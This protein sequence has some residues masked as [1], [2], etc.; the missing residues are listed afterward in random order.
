M[1]HTL[2]QAVVAALQAHGVR[3][4]FG[5]PGGGSSLDIIDAAHAVG[6]EFVL[7][8]TESAAAIMAAVTGELSS[9]PGTV[10]TAI[11]PGAASAVNGVAYAWLERAPLVLISDSVATHDV[12]T[13]HQRFDQRALF[14]PVTKRSEALTRDAAGGLDE[15]VGLSLTAPPGPVHL[16]L[17]AAEAG[18]AVASLTRGSPPPPPPAA[19]VSGDSRRA[20]RLLAGAH[21]PVVIA[22]L[23]ARE[24]AACRALRTLLTRMLC[25]V[26]P[27]YKA[28]G[29]VPDADTRV[30][31]MFTG[32][33]AEARCLE[34]ADLIVLY[35][36]DPVELIPGEWRYTAPVLELTAWPQV[37]AP[38][39]PACTLAGPLDELVEVFG[40]D[41]LACQW[42]AGEIAGLRESL[43]RRLEVA[44]STRSVDDVVAALAS[45]APA[46]S[47]LTVDAGAHMF[48][49]MASWQALAPFDVLKSN[50]LSTMAYA[51][52]AGIA[53]SLHEPQ[54]WVIAVTGDGGLMM[55]L[56][57]LA[58]AA[59]LGCRIVVV[60]CNDAA[61]SLIDVKQ[62]RQGRPS[63]GVRYPRVDFAA[64]ARGLG[65]QA[66]RIEPQDALEPALKAAFDG[67][68]PALLDVAVDPRPYRGQLE[69]LRG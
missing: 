10:I 2:A 38:T 8:Q 65:V 58:T 54:R 23:Q 40:A 9:T 68:G 15:L 26:M 44:S 55:C 4:I 14:A 27:T 11:G 66:W 29:V 50:G 52:P 19:P 34:S 16:D 30:V 37:S 22:G 60:V 35:G 67:A 41:E 13:R 42:P 39:T 64:A 33:A 53:A 48:S 57:E 1:A 24:E 31:G 49:L 32:A 47:R 56:A 43:R 20:R 62:Q 36:V 7:A 25:P 17:S 3:R 45:F 28:K 51:L 59:R 61:L 63:V 12:H 5:V 69:A 21:R 46:H 6:I 18:A